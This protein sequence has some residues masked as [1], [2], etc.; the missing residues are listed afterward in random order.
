MLKHRR[1]GCHGYLSG[2]I[3]QQIDYLNGIIYIDRMENKDIVMDRVMVA[4]EV[5]YDRPVLP[6][7]PFPVMS[8]NLEAPITGNESFQNR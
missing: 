1:L 4:M 3:Q 2:L 8:P 7:L 5:G 6:V